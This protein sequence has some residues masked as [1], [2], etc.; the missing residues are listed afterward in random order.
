MNKS[1]YQALT[2]NFTYAELCFLEDAL[3][4]YNPDYRIDVPLVTELKETVTAA[5]GWL[6]HL[7]KTDRKEF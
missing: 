6:H 7:N 2:N 4:A 5:R 1:Q 3:N